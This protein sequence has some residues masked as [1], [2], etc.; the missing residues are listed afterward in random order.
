MPGKKAADESLT[1][2]QEL[3]NSMLEC[4]DRFQQEVD[5]R[6]KGM[7]CISDR[8]AVLESSNLIETSK[9]EL[10]KFVQSLVENYN[11]L[12]ADGILTEITRL[13]RFLKAAKLPKEESLGWT[14]LR[15]LEFVVGYVF[16]DSVPNLTLALRFFLA[17]CVSVASC[18]RSFSKLQLIKNCLRST[19]N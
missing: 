13:R 5:T 12:S 2:D 18:E 17:L 9:T 8:F 6:C 3:K 1:L 15:F 10:P 11:E 4:I 7:D 16:F 14:S 19:V